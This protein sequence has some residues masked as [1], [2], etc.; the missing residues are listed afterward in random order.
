MNAATAHPCTEA[1][2]ECGNP[3]APLDK[4]RVLG[5]ENSLAENGS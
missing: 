3:H 2:N 5:E 4:R 1:K